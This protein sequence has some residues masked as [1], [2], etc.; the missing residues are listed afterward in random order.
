MVLRGVYVT[1]EQNN[2]KDTTRD[3]VK[4]LRKLGNNQFSAE[5]KAQL[6][7]KAAVVGE[8]SGKGKITA[9]AVEVNAKTSGT[10]TGVSV[11]GVTAGASQP[12][13][14]GTGS[15]FKIPAQIAGAGSASVNEISGN[16]A[17]LLE[18]V[19]VTT[20]GTNRDVKVSAS[21]DSMIGAYSGAA[22][23]KKKGRQANSGGFSATLAGAV[24]YNEVKT[25]VTA[26]IKD[27]SIENTKRITN[28][29]AREGAVV[30]AGLA[31]GVDTS[32]QG[33]GNATAINAGV[34]AS[35]NEIN[36]STHAVMNNVDTSASGGDKTDIANIAQSKDIQVAGG[37]TAQYAKGGGIGIGAAV[38]S[39]HAANDIQSRI[40]NSDLNNVGTLKAYAQSDLVQVGTVLSAGVIQ[41]QNGNGVQAAV[42]DNQLVNNVNVTI[43]GKAIN[44][45]AI[46]AKAFDG[47]I[48][49]TTT[50]LKDLAADGFDVDGKD[51]MADV[52]AANADVSVDKDKLGA[53]KK[54]ED[55]KEQGDDGRSVSAFKADDKK[56]NLIVSG[57]VSVIANT[58]S[59]G[60]VAAGA[61]A[62]N[63]KISNNFTTNIKGATIN[64]N[65]VNAKAESDTLMVGATAGVAVS[66]GQQGVANIAGSVGV[67]QLN[68]NT[69]ST[70]EDSRIT[71]DAIEAQQ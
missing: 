31:L 2:E 54:D 44:A 17:A 35:V 23:L 25:G 55:G 48:T 41:G 24:A 66:T 68:N 50:Y 37:I 21:D 7:T 71:A 5:E 1:D 58:S 29:A 11:A 69:T 39:L 67:M 28:Q 40:T 4:D 46:D 22:A 61:A 52:N 15:G 38:S 56:G 9:N 33:T 13:N 65:T 36:N 10:I 63:Q 51:A 32:G 60:K 49:A 6:G 57:A 45:E 53:E 42:A 30:A 16:T 27:A 26:Q 43:E 8:A 34:S 47:E 18:G 62:V 59:Q 12:N 19:E 64:A 14:R 3:E 70:I 20:A